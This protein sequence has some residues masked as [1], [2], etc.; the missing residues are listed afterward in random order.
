MIVRA[1]AMLLASLVLAAPGAADGV[2]G[3]RFAEL[4]A[5]APRDATALAQL[6]RVTAV[7]G[8]RVD[9]RAALADAGSRELPGRLAALAGTGEARAPVGSPRGAARRILAQP[10]YTG[11]EPRNALQRALAWIGSKLRLPG[12]SNAVGWLVLIIVAAGLV[13]FC[14]SVIS[15]RSRRTRA[16]AVQERAILAGESDPTMLERAADE[17][18]GAGDLE[19]A[20]RL[21]VAAALIRLQR[22]RRI[23][24]R[25]ET[26][27]GAASRALRSAS[28]RP[29]ASLFDAVV[30]GRRTA[31]P[32]DLTKV[33]EGIAETLAEVPR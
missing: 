26:T 10:R 14:V 1:A 29:V 6:E 7:D 9:L 11:R 12:G 22:A 16:R 23:E 8:Q 32:E 19:R 17:A 4:V 13:A 33:R 5:R 2:D 3:T 27:V 18:E 25:P 20:L 31:R 30:Y 28:F 21:R 15:A 24:L